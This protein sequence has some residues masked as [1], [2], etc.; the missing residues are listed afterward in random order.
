M[1]DVKKLETQLQRSTTVI[2]ETLEMLISKSAKN[3][4]A[5]NQIN[6]IAK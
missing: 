5:L 2:N 6:N 3:E 1:K 4:Q